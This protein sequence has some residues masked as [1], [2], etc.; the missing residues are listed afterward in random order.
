MTLHQKNDVS[1]M[2]IWFSIE[3]ANEEFIVFISAKTLIDHFKA[4]N[5]KNSQLLA[6]K[7]NQSVIDA[8]ARRKLLN[9]Y[10]RPIHL[11][12]DDFPRQNGSFTSNIEQHTSGSVIP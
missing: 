5:T 12:T 9:G 8:V 6:Y 2:G 10:P 3:I 4:A 7:R 1:R 11:N